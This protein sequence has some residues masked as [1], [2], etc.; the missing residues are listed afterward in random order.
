[1]FYLVLKHIG[2]GSK[3]NDLKKSVSGLTGTNDSFDLLVNLLEF[4]ECHVTMLYLYNYRTK[5]NSQSLQTEFSNI[6]CII[7]YISENKVFLF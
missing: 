2:I 1:M 7:N 3:S 5:L 6:I 4:I